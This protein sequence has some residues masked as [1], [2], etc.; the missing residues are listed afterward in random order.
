MGTTNSC[1]AVYQKDGTIKIIPDPLTGK[2]TIPSCVA[3]SNTSCL[4]GSKAEA[5]IDSNPLNTV[6]DSK[7]LMGLKFSDPSVQKD[8][9]KWPFEVVDDAQNRP[10][11][12]LKQKDNR[13]SLT[14]VQIGALL[15]QSL[16]EQ[17]EGYLKRKVTDAVITVPAN[18]NQSQREATAEARKIA[19]LNVLR[20]INEPTAAAMCLAREIL[21]GE[22]KQIADDSTVCIYDLGGGTFDVTILKLRGKH[23]TIQ[24]LSTCGDTHLGGEDFD[25][26]LVDHV[27]KMLK[28][29]TK[30]TSISDLLMRRIR[31]TCNSSK[32]ILT[33]APETEIK[34]S[35]FINGSEDVV[36]KRVLFKR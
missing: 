1:V 20:T 16:K 36:L 21:C 4:I 24:V 18:F 13:I 7:R 32:H 22:Q 27:I 5:Q 35:N 30:A 10:I 29:K 14:P 31:T 8:L 11:Y 28:E 34:I 12:H 3:F 17:A 6:T 26:T 9:R 33:N 19:G 2:P 15:L 23:R 25:N